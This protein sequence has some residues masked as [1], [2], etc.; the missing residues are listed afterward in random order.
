[1]KFQRRGFI[2]WGL[3]T[4]VLSAVPVSGQAQEPDDFDE[5]FLLRTETLSI[6]QGAT[7]ESRTQFSVLHSRELELRFHVEN[8]SG[9]RWDVDKVEEYFF[10]KEPLQITKLYFSNLYLGEDFNL[11]VL[12]AS[13]QVVD[14]R[15]FRSLDLSKKKIRYTVASCMDEARHDSKIWKDMVNQQPDIILFVGD[16]V[17]ADRKARVK[18]ERVLANPEL[19]WKR[20]CQARQTLYIYHSP[21]L[22]P[23]LATWDDHD[24]GK[25]DMGKEYP[26]V[27]ES[28]KNF[29]QFFAQEESHCRGLSR[30][31]GVSSA[32]HF[33]DQLFLL[34]DDRS[35]RERSGS[36]K[37]NAHW[38]TAQVEW[39][40]SQIDLNPGF[41]WIC[42][43]SQ[44]FPAMIF[45]ESVSKEHPE[46]LESLVSQL[47]EKNQRVAFVSGD[48]HFSEISEI[49]SSQL[50]YQTYELTSS[51]IHSATFPGVPGIVPNRRRIVATGK[52]NY[53]LIEALKQESE[54]KMK[55]VSHS[56]DG[57][58]NF[59]R[60][61][62]V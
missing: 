41:T 18:E 7:D 2:K 28:Q 33:A 20:F 39:A 13:D 62:R 57:R 49:E 10:E 31:P 51:S 11:F 14:Q 43:G 16:A 32:L 9:E 29:L 30:G 48:V 23:I 59:S 40:L 36:K 52:R 50:G 58:T 15:S 34:L 3:M 42:N 26:Y 56:K 27:E 37:P 45:K 25:N 12:N 44:I 60:N 61:L 1:M 53:L 47:R 54:M 46:Q 24:F 19:L 38:G 5:N 55:V 8:S 6:L 21:V 4:S 35:F 22:I 17:Y